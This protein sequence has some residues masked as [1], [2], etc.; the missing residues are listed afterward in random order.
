VA[1]QDELEK[2]FIAA[3]RRRCIAAR[4]DLEQLQ[5]FCIG[6]LTHLPQHSHDGALDFVVMGCERICEALYPQS[7]EL[8]WDED[9]ER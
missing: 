6:V 1:N 8:G 2:K 4:R 9:D 3:H 7:G 5:A